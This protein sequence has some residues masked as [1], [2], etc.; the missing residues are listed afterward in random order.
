MA[1]R[2]NPNLKTDEEVLGAATAHG[3]RVYEGPKVVN[4][5]RAN[6]G[7]AYKVSGKP[8]RNAGVAMSHQDSALDKRKPGS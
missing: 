8:A 5:N 3:I 1:Y 6:G 4:I 2:K 7:G